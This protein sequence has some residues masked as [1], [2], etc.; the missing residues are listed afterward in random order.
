LTLPTLRNALHERPINESR[1][2]IKIV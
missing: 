2:S 1:L